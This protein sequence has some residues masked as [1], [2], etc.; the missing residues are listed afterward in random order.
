MHHRA[1]ALTTGLVAIVGLAAAGAHAQSQSRPPVE[2]FYAVT[3]FDAK[4]DGS[5]VN[6]A[7]LQRAIDTASAAGGGTVFFP[8][9]RYVSGTLVLKDH[10]TLWLD[11]GALLLAST[12]LAD[13][14]RHSPAYRSYS[15]TYVNQALLYAEG[16]RHIGVVGQGIIDG[17]GGHPAFAIPA[18]EVG[19]LQRPYLIRFV[20]CQD[21]RVEGITLRDSP[22]WVQQY[23]ACDRVNISGIT[24]AS[25]V[26]HNNDM[27]DIDGCHDVHVTGCTGDTGDDAI[28]LKSTGERLCENVTISNCT[29]G[30]NCNGIKLGTET[31]GGFRNIAIANCTIR[32]SRFESVLYSHRNGSSGITLQ[33][34]DGGIL[35]NVTIS[36]IAI[37]GTLSPLFIRLG[38][39]ARR[40]VPDAPP[41]GQGR[42]R[43]VVISNVVASGAGRLGSA[44]TGLPDA[45]IENVTLR[46]IRLTL[47]G[48]GTADDARRQ[49]EEK[50]DG[51]PECTMFG[52]LPAYGLFVR[53]VK[54]L[55]MDNVQVAFE[56]PDRRPAL[57][58]LDVRDLRIN[59]FRAEQTT[60][61]AETMVMTDVVGAL[62]TGCV[63]PPQVPFISFVGRR[64]ADIVLAG[65]VLGH[66]P[67][68]RLAPEVD[69][70]GI[71]GEGNPRIEK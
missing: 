26:N 30:S 20:S 36:N 40:H 28:T 5:T 8:A 3:A 13:Y 63:A 42:L 23:L 24:V 22:M 69:P 10:V 44:I 48:G 57:V 50:P 32:P 61:G 11:N 68:W 64:T 31:T 52:T 55:V 15:D 45:M 34:V 38:N 4:S 1:F 18:G 54:G 67:P 62:I 53:H 51:Y 35:E 59:G 19:Y 2:G 49:I 39:R 65:N 14:P 6:T 9:G 70:R 37:R 43:N 33:I 25:N 16:A 12:D 21:V 7:A 29:V 58:C 71:L 41:P 60:D 27:L 17:R 66:E 47:E 56:R 46:D